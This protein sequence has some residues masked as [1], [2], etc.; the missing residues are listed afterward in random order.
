MRRIWYK[1]KVFFYLLLAGMIV[2]CT[3]PEIVLLRP[4][5][6]PAPAAQGLSGERVKVYFTNP[7][8]AESKAYRGGPAEA[9]VSAIDNALFQ[10]D[11]AAYDLDLW[12]LRDA[13]IRAHR[14]GVEVRLVIEKD[15]E[16]RKEIRDLREAGIPTAADTQD[17]LMHHKFLVIDR[18]EV[19]TGS[20]NFTVNGAY[21]HANHLLRISSRRLADNFTAEFEEMFLEGFFGPDVLVNTPYPRLEL[22]GLRVETYFAPDDHPER[23]ILQAISA[24]RESIDF[25]AFSY[26]SDS[27][28]RTMREQASR[29]VQV[30]GVFDRSQVK[31]NR[32]S[33]Y[34]GLLEA[35][36]PVCRDGSGAKMHH[37]VIVI[38]G[39]IVI[40]GSYNFS[41]SAE[42]VNDENLLILEHPGL[43]EE[44]L[45]EFERIYGS[46]R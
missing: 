7:K 34:A 40:T 42:E 8:S 15:H 16:G 6:T 21:R 26:T 5:P 19:W 1:F 11:I 12:V 45:Q 35:G 25:L 9:L 23:A 44:F 17:G 36:L 3:P 39:R 4:L 14:R 2:G 24:A 33:E 31:S 13:L 22:S 32:G 38:D 18:E 20:M 30:R 37:K 10:V 28:A 43:A 27:I 29:G 46:C 41:R